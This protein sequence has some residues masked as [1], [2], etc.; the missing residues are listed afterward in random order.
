MEEDAAARRSG[1]RGRLLTRLLSRLRMLGN[2]E[3]A[4]AKLVGMFA[5]PPKGLSTALLTQMVD[6]ET[7]ELLASVAGA[8][9]SV[10]RLVAE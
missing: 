5:G 1:T 4:A 9:E 10:L 8:A 2:K 3:P 7:D 6:D